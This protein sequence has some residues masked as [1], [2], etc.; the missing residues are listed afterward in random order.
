MIARNRKMVSS[1][2]ELFRVH[3]PEETIGR[4]VR[5]GEAAGFT[6]NCDLNPIFGH[7]PRPPCGISPAIWR[8]QE[9]QDN[10]MMQLAGL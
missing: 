4:P 8:M 3:S 1:Q 7:R 10:S 5:E 9:R 6:Q 2:G